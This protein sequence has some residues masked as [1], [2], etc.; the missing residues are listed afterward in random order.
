MDARKDGVKALWQRDDTEHT[1]AMREGGNQRT[2]KGPW[3]HRVVCAKVAD[4]WAGHVRLE[5][6]SSKE[7]EANVARREA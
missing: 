5:G 2:A 7:K 4:S 3:L 6:S 1:R